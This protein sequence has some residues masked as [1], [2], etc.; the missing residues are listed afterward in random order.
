MEHFFNALLK[1]VLVTLV[2]VV[3][4]PENLIACTTIPFTLVFGA[5]SNT[6]YVPNQKLSGGALHSVHLQ[7][8]QSVFQCGKCV[9]CAADW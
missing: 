7:F 9:C 8:F 4:S 2:N 1:F 6:L 3:D 5:V